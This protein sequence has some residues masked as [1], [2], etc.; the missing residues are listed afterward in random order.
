MGK[1]PSFFT[2]GLFLI[3][4]TISSSDGLMVKTAQY[5][6]ALDN[7]FGSDKYTY[8]DLYGLSY[9]PAFKV[10]PEA[11]PETKPCGNQRNINLYAICDSYLWFFVKDGSVFCGVDN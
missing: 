5:R 4:F 1:L 8:G 2:V 6:Y 7:V 10:K 11:Q 9:L 3:V